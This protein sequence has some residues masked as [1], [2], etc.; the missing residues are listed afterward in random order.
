LD[1]EKGVH[2]RIFGE[3]I[4]V[5]H[6]DDGKA[7]FKR[8]TKPPF[9]KATLKRHL[10]SLEARFGPSAGT[11]ILTFGSFAGCFAMAGSD[12]SPHSFNLLSRSFRRAQLI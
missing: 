4:E 11:G 10:A 12:A 9:R 7:F 6:V 8:G 5:S 3:A 1:E 2:H